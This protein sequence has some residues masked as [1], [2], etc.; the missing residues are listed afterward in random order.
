MKVS[1]ILKL[2]VFIAFTLAQEN[3]IVRVTYDE[4]TSLRSLAETHLNSPN[5][6]EIILSYNGYKS[7]SD[8]SPG[9]SLLLPVDEFKKIRTNLNGYAKYISS[10]N[11]EGAILLAKEYIDNADQIYISVIGA[12]K[13]GNLKKAVDLS[14]KALTAAKKAFTVTKE[15]RTQSISAKLQDKDGKVQSRK[16][17]NTSW[18]ET[19]KDQELFEKEKVRTLKNATGLIGFVDGSHITMGE[20]ALVVIEH[21]KQDVINRTSRSDVMILEGDASTYLKSST[22]KNRMNIKLPGVQ[23]SIRSSR[24]WVSR[25]EKEVVRLANFDGEL[26]VFTRQGSVTI[27]K[28]EGSKI[29][30]GK[31]PEKPK[32][33]LESPVIKVPETGKIQYNKTVEFKWDMVK[34]AKNYKIQIA[35]DPKFLE[36]LAERF[37]RRNSYRWTFKKQGKYSVRVSSVNADNLPGSYSDITQFTLLVDNTSPYLNVRKPYNGFVSY[38]NTVEVEGEVEIGSKVTVNGTSVSIDSGGRFK[39]PVNVNVGSNSIVAKAVDLAGNISTIKKTVIGVDSREL[40]NQN[41][42]RIT[43][44]KE[45]ISIKQQVRPYTEYRLESQSLF[46]AKKD[47]DFVVST[48]SKQFNLDEISHQKKSKTISI[49]YDNIKPKLRLNDFPEFTNESSVLLNG[50]LNKDV[51]VFINGK[52][53]SVNDKKVRYEFRLRPGK[54]ICVFY[55][56]DEAGNSV[57]KKVT[58]V[59]DDQKPTL[60][61][62]YWI[63]NVETSVLIIEANGTG[64]PLA[65]TCKVL[66][67]Q[68]NI[69]ATLNEKESRYELTVPKLFKERIKHIEIIDYALNSV[70]VDI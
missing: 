4:N 6:W 13:S 29:E 9:A 24:F 11:K 26:D 53:V 35:T 23:T 36:I 39:T 27:K 43:T 48:K 42:E 49:T 1:L 63:D 44:N 57:E 65:R 47:I 61:K 56:I 22:G 66:M 67:N 46:S 17:N 68:G 37:P 15:K 32:K 34:G 52:E 3:K 40:F 38:E 54:N 2:F 30:P 5:D 55:L 16:K 64:S 7:P 51:S 18:S 45:E 58:I 70:K 12:K 31:A 60:T 25:D 28:N 33:L 50:L 8:I 14:Q 20:N 69:L 21:S 19:K 10:A 62:H 41:A 59:R